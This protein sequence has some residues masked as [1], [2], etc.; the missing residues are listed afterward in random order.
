[1]ARRE[2]RGAESTI[3]PDHVVVI[4]E[5]GSSERSDEEENDGS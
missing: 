3:D 5:Q 4:I 1:M 2:F